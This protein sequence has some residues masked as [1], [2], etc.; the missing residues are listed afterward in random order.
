M[1]F[2]YRWVGL[3]VMAAARGISDNEEHETRGIAHESRANRFLLI[4]AIAL[5]RSRHAASADGV[6]RM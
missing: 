4:C 3:V 2:V 5:R 6:I 1:S